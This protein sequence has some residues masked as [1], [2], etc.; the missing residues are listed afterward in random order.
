[1]EILLALDIK[2]ILQALARGH[3]CGVCVFK[4]LLSLCITHSLFKSKIKLPNI[5]FTSATVQEDC[6]ALVN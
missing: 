1:M 6:R 4:V 3:R 2:Q 5:C